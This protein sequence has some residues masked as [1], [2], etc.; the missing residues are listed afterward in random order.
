MLTYKVERMEE[1]KHTQQHNSIENDEGNSSETGS[2]AI[3]T[4]NEIRATAKE[5]I[6]N[7]IHTR[8]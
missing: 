1:F 6:P 5:Q 8:A 3:G 7:V 4:E 2:E